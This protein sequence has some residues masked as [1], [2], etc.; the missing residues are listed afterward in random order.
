MKAD[1]DKFSQACFATQSTLKN[2]TLKKHQYIV[3]KLSKFTLY[4]TI[5]ST[6][7]TF[8]HLLQSNVSIID[9]LSEKDCMCSCECEYLSR[10]PTFVLLHSN[11]L[12]VPSFRHVFTSFNYMT[13]S[14]IMYLLITKFSNLFYLIEYLYIFFSAYFQRSL[15]KSPAL[16]LAALSLTLL[17]Q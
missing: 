7:A 5:N 4:L 14:I 9:H 12:S 16:F 13:D 11:F 10:T 15:N 1:H 6:H 8:L 3:F 2:D 17:F